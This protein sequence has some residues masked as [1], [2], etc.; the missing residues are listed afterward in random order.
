MLGYLLRKLKKLGKKV[1]CL[2]VIK[3][4]YYYGRFLV[5]LGNVLIVPFCGLALN[6][7]F[8]LLSSIEIYVKIM[9]SLEPNSV[10]NIPK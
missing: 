5:D 4:Q 9:V 1:L 10:P 7:R 3:D 8:F 6:E 2:V